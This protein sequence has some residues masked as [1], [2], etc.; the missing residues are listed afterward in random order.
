[1][2]P[3][4]IKIGQIELSV[5]EI[6]E[7]IENGHLELEDDSNKWNRY[8]MS[9]SIES[10]LLGLTMTPIYVDASNPEKW[11]V[12]DGTKR[13]NALISFISGKFSLYDLE[14]LDEYTSFFFNKLPKTIQRRLLQSKFTIYS[15]NQ[16][17]P[18]EVRLSLI[19][20][21]VPDIKNGLSLKMRQSLLSPRAKDLIDQLSS[22]VIYQKTLEYAMT[23]NNLEL[24]VNYL[25]ALY[26][27]FKNEV[28]T[29]FYSYAKSEDIIIMTN[30]YAKEQKQY[31]FIVN[32]WQ[33][34]LH[35][36][37][38]LFENYAFMTSRNSIYINKIVFNS[39]I[40][41]FGAVID[42]YSY[43]QILLKK[44]K[45]NDLW[46]ELFQK[47][48]GKKIFSRKP[49][50]TKINELTKITEQLTAQQ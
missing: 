13:L 38:E 22:N 18:P 23:K 47:G 33:I 27:H 9:M 4:E 3:S 26:W 14:L 15:I 45:F 19:R 48:P 46:F 44:Q 21:I 1:M 32:V 41:Y 37:H 2:H 11:L 10:I 42:H 28:F 6:V 24:E 40:I 34:G 7:M 50:G 16:G 8:G 36:V 49:P 30:F 12:L 31:S 25:H 43:S 35:R 5:S 20:R 17:V 29:S 39:L